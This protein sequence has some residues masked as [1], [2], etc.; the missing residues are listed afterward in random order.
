RANVQAALFHVDADGVLAAGSLGHEAEGVVARELFVEFCKS[1]VQVVLI[2]NRAAA[3]LIGE[4]LNRTVEIGPNQ[5]RVEAR[6]PCGTLDPFVEALHATRVNGEELNAVSSG[7]PRET[8]KL[9]AEICLH[10]I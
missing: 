6:G 8:S 3:G 1:D 5:T 10:G 2:V 7:T 9:Q 4:K